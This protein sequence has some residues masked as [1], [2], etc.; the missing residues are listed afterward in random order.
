MDTWGEDGPPTEAY[1]RVTNAERFRPLHE[2]ADD[3]LADHERRFAVRRT[4]STETDPHGTDPARAVTLTPDD[5][6]AASVTVVFDAFPGLRVLVAGGSDGHLPVCGCDACEES[7]ERCADELR[8]WLTAITAG[9]VTERLI[10]DD[11]WWYETSRSM[12]GR[13]SRS[14][15]RVDGDRLESLRTRLPNGE[16][17]WAP[18]PPRV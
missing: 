16:L 6:S 15:G 3:L 4:E 12:D 10:Y 18:W 5:P 7:F 2:F 17:T 13:S 1:G 11:G 14:R 8:W 9:A